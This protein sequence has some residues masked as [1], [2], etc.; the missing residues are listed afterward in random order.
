MNNN[1]LNYIKDLSNADKKTLSQK[2]LKLFEEGGELAKKILPFE[3]AEGTRHRFTNRADILE[4]VADVI[5]VALSIGYDVNMTE[6]ELE[7][8]MLKKAKYWQELQNNE[9]KALKS[10]P[11]EIHVTID[12]SQ[13]PKKYKAENFSWFF[14]ICHDIN[15]KPLLLK[16]Y[17]SINDT[18][19][20]V[21]MANSTIRGTANEA[22]KLMEKIAS[23]IT[24]YGFSPNRKKIETVPWHPAALKIKENKKFYFENHLKVKMKQNNFKRF[25]KQ[26]K[27]EF[28]PDKNTSY[29]ISWNAIK[30]AVDGIRTY[31]VTIRSKETTRED[32]ESYAKIFSNLISTNKYVL[33]VT[34]ENIEL[35]IFDSAIDQDKSWIIN[36]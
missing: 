26:L 13:Y 36:G 16:N 31:F 4:E 10:L 33:E 15:V 27:E 3:D 25:I 22:D 19:E 9:S 34:A 12:F 6:E 14:R 18:V 30:D 32:F 20:T 5:L 24:T 29:G 8:V 17:S 21:V 35:A 11:Y 1:L 28:N 2:G 7:D 23:D